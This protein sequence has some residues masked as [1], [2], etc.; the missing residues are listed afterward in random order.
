MA[1]RFRIDLGFPALYASLSMDTKGITDGVVV[2]DK[3][4]QQ[5]FYTGSYGSGGGGGGSID[6]GSFL[7]NA[8]ATLNTLTFT[9]GDGSTF[10][11]TINTGSG[12]VAGVTS[13]EGLT[14]AIDL[15]AGSGIQITNNE[16]NAITITNTQEGYWE[17]INNNIV[18]SGSLDVI[19]TSSLTID[20]YNNEDIFLVK[21]NNVPKVKVN[22]QGVLT[23]MPTGSFPT[24][25]TGGMI[26]KDNEFYFGYL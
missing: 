8:T 7:I 21:R 15:I 20:Q 25:V 22:N 6:T 18:N 9:Q 10:N 19:I 16:S 2:Y 23:L 13:L 5:L 17:L 11:V 26:Y 1:E 12:G 3:E 4:R 14:G 24:A